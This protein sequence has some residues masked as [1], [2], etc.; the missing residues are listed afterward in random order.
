MRGVARDIVGVRAEMVVGQQRDAQRPLEPRPA[1]QG[2]RVVPHHMRLRVRKRAKPA[3]AALR[4][5]ERPAH[6]RV[7]SRSL[8]WPAFARVAWHSLRAF[9]PLQRLDDLA[10]AGFGLLALLLLALDD[11][12]G[13]VGDELRIAELR[14]RRA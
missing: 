7:A 12:L 2:Q 13:R 11:L 1:R 9:Q 14:R 6:S 4:V 8:E 3:L 5:G 10:A